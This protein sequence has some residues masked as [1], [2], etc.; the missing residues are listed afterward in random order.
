MR[1]LEYSELTP[2]QRSVAPATEFTD[3]DPPSLIDRIGR[4]RPLVERLFRYESL[5][6]V[7]RGVPVARVATTRPVFVTDSGD[8]EV[9]CGVTDVITRAD[10]VRR[11]LA[12]RL[13]Q[14]THRRARSEG[15]RW[16]FLW[17]R[18]SWAAH[19]T[20]ERLG[21]RD[22]YSP[23]VALRRYERAPRRSRSGVTVRIAR[24]RDAARLD[25]LLRDASVDR[26]GYS[27]RPAGWFA[28]VFR[29]G[30]REP[31]GFRLLYAGGRLAGYVGA[32]L[33]RFDLVSREVVVP[34]PALRRPVLDAL[35]RL[36]GDRWIGFR[37]T[38]FVR[39]AERLLERRGYHR[40]PCDHAVMMACRLGPDEAAGWESLRR[41]IRDPRFA[42]HSGDMV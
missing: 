34:D 12:L 27:R 5:H 25:Q 39:D 8:E 18:R 36:A 37:S 29:L 31:G 3:G 10:A 4:Y 7:E 6:A 41:T 33:D 21:Y 38:T 35:E 24:A 15:L 23:S 11:H 13:M 32:A 20:Y 30:W 17:T 22:V 2:E 40:V 28:G 9:V 42:L 19:R 1:I 16:A 14:E 26:I